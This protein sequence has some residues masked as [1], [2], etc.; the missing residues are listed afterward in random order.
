MRK[1]WSQGGLNFNARWLRNRHI[2]NFDSNRSQSK[3]TAHSLESLKPIADWLRGRAVCSREKALQSL[4]NDDCC[5]SSCDSDLFPHFCQCRFP[6]TQRQHDE[7][8]G[9]VRNFMSRSLNC[10]LYQPLPLCP[11]SAAVNGRPHSSFSDH[12]RRFSGPTLQGSQDWGDNG[13]KTRRRIAP[14]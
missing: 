7:R 3:G 12:R 9:G 4:P 8:R 14:H 10:G 13:V 2:A 5:S 11:D 6:N 1:R